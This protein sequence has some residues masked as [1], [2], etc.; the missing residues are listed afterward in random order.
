MEFFFFAPFEVPLNKIW[1]CGNNSTPHLRFEAKFLW[2]GKLFR[3]PICQNKK[4]T[5]FLPENE[6]VIAFTGFIHGLSIPYFIPVV[7]VILLVLV[8]LFYYAPRCC[9][10]QSRHNT[11]RS[12]RGWNGTVS[13]LPHLAQVISNDWRAP[14]PSPMRAFLAERHSGQRTGAFWKPFCW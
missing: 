1:H 9:R 6:V 7:L 10:K 13:F 14:P 5:K 3:Q 8:V 4:I 12:P 2:R 11:G